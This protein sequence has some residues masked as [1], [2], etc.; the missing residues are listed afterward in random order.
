[1]LKFGRI[2][3]NGSR[4]LLS[5]YQTTSGEIYQTRPL[6]PKTHEFD[7]FN[8]NVCVLFLITV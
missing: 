4:K 7:R 5:N 3:D 2:S 8:K 1:M 6:F